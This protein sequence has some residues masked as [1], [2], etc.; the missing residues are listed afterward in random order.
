MLDE[1]Y[2]GD[3]DMLTYSRR[4][5]VGSL[6]VV[7]PVLGTPAGL[8]TGPIPEN[9]ATEFATRIQRY[10]TTRQDS[11]PALAG[12]AERASPEAVLDRRARLNERIRTARKDTKPGDILF[13]DLVAAIVGIFR[14]DTFR[15]TGAQATAMARETERPPNN[16]PVPRVNDEFPKDYGLVSP[17]ATILVR[18]PELPDVL[19]YRLIGPHLVVRDIEANLIVDVAPHVLS[20]R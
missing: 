17:P 13:P 5:L 3:A 19:E 8:Q 2:L 11:M 15:I 6:I 16:V 20:A 12:T 7:S 1:S 18:L 9:V 14:S 10:M 4:L